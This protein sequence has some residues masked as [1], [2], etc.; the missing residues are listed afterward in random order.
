MLPKTDFPNSRHSAGRDPSSD[1]VAVHASRGGVGYAPDV[2]C[3]RVAGNLDCTNLKGNLE[4]SIPLESFP[5]ATS[6]SEEVR[7]LVPLE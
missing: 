1:G 7:Y 3:I 6:G 4:E 2:F 5:E